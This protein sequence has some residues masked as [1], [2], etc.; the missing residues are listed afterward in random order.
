VDGREVSAEEAMRRSK[1]VREIVHL[2]DGVIHR[3]WLQ[4]GQV[5]KRHDL[6]FDGTPIRHLYYQN[7]RLFKREYYSRDRDHVST[8]LFDSE[9]FIAESIH[10]R[11]HWW[12]EQ[13]VPKR[14]ESGSSLFVKEG[15][16][17]IRKR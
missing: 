8:E 15:D 7:E 9:G 5:T 2:R 13:G 4:Q 6:N 12:Y 10:G 17:W 1:A 16:H 11:N 3:E 14:F